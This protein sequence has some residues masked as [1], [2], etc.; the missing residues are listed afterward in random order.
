MEENQLWS[1]TRVLF[2]L[3]FCST[4]LRVMFLFLHEAQFTGY[5]DENTPFGV[6]DTIP[7]AISTLEEI[8]EKL[9]IWFSD[10]QMKSNIDKCHLL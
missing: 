6:R 10:N 8:R 9:L 1:T 5:A 7:D 4:S 3:P 2:W